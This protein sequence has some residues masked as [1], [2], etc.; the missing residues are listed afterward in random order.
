MRR[1][2]FSL[3]LGLFV[4]L[5]AAA[6]SGYTANQQVEV[7]WKDRWYKATILAV[8]DKAYKIHYDGY[9]A[10]SDETVPASRIRRL[11]GQ[12]K[13]GTPAAVKYGRYGCTASK[14]VN[15]A[16]EYAPKGS[17][18]LAPNGSYTYYGFAKPSAGKFSVNAAGVVSFS[19]GYFTGGQA[20]PIEGRENRYY[21]VFPANPDNRWTCSWSAAK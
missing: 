9:A 18:V 13:T 16:Y 8:T 21:V 4:A 1:R 2:L 12:G 6:Q 3:L 11:G 5:S 20:T 10:S 15:G 17:F 7:L 14:Y 19:G